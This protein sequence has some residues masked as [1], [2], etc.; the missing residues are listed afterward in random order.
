ME[1]QLLL[2]IPTSGR[3]DWLTSHFGRF[4]PGTEHRHP[5]NTRQGGPQSRSGRFGGK[6]F[7]CPTGIRSPDRPNSSAVVVPL[8]SARLRYIMR[9]FYIYRVSQEECAIRLREG[10]PYVK[11][12]RYNP[13][14]LCPK[15]NGYGDKGQRSLKL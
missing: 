4:T 12:H 5:L 13:K 15:M 14:H 11:V 2:L 1:V 8:A 9:A 3:G 10:V 7:C 6:N